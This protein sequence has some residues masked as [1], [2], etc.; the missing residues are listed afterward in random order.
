[1]AEAISKEEFAALV[2][3]RNLKI[4]PKQF[5]EFR[6]IYAHILK[7]RERIRSPRGYGAEPASVFRAKEI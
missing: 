4:T 3:D 7:V 2:K 6:E 1:M 5:D